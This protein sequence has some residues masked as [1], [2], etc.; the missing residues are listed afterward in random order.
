[1]STPDPRRWSGWPLVVLGAAGVLIATVAGVVSHATAS[2]GTSAAPAASTAPQTITQTV[3][4]SSVS[5]VT[6]A[7][8]PGVSPAVQFGDGTH[9][10]GLDVAPGDYRTPGP[11]GTNEGGCYWSRRKAVGSTMTDYGV[12]RGPGQITIQGGELVEINGCQ[13]WTHT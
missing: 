11:S 6:I 1:M 13:P 2:G 3:T 7:A 5:T 9:V 12:V 10:V 8:S 4:V